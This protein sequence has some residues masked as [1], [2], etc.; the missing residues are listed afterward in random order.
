MD[1]T[2]SHAI[3][4]LNGK[5]CDYQHAAKFHITRAEGTYIQF[6]LGCYL[7]AGMLLAFL[8]KVHGYMFVCI[9]S[10]AFSFSNLN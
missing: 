5:A 1:C 6:I 9:S 7:L 3:A 8:I 4:R 2:S 10:L